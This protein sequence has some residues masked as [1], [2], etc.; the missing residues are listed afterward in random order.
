MTW[1][2]IVS[3]CVLSAT[4]LAGAPPPTPQRLAIFY[5]IPSLVNG[6]GGD[7][8]RAAAVFAEYDLVV[9]GD[10]LEFE[11]VVRARKPAGAG[12]VEYRRTKEIMARLAASPRATAVFGY[13]SGPIAAALHGGDL[14]AC[15]AMES[16]G[17]GRYLLR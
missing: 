3:A 2:S 17:R 14:D 9:L 5:G 4:V 11:D 12:A 10:G 7:V 15:D 16:H 6:A 8:G 1:P 13:V